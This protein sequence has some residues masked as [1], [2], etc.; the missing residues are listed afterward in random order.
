MND[1]K[2]LKF[3][4][5]P[6]NEDFIKSGYIHSLDLRGKCFREYIRGVIKGNKL[7]LR[8]Y[9]PYNP[10]DISGFTLNELYSKSRKILELYIRDLS[11]LIKWEYKIIIKDIIYNADKDLYNKGI[12]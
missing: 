9:Y 3:S 10:D 1:I 11:G 4:Y 7:Y 8:A 2:D 5:N 12:S 6:F